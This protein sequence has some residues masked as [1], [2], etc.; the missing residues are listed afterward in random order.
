[1]TVAS[2]TNGRL[3]L[4]D[5]TTEV[6]FLGPGN[7]WRLADPY[8]RP[9]ISALKGGGVKRDSA[10]AD[11]QQLVFGVY[12]NA[13]ETIPLALH[14]RSQVA[15]IETSRI[16]LKLLR[17]AADY[18]KEPFEY[19]P[20]WIEAQPACPGALV[21]YARV[22]QG[23]L[24]ELGNVFGQ[25]FFAPQP[26][27][28]MEGLTLVLE[29]EPFWTSV[30]P[31][32]RLGPLYNLL[33][34][35]DFEL[36]TQR[37]GA[38]S[39]VEPDSW[40]N[41]A[42][43]GA[44]GR[45][46]RH[47]DHPN[48]GKHCLLVD[49]DSLAGAGEK[50]VYQVVEGIEDETEYTLILWAR[51][52]GIQYGSGRVW[53]RYGTQTLTVYASAARHDW[54]LYTGKFTT[55]RD[56]VVI[57]YCEIRGTGVG[58]I[59]SAAEG[60]VYFDSFMLLP[61]DWE[62]LAEA[63]LLPYLTSSHVVNHCDQPRVGATEAGDINYLD[64]WDVPGDV[65]ASVRLEMVNDTAAVT[66]NS[67]VEVIAACRVG[68][69]RTG[70][71]FLLDNVSDPPGPN[72]TSASSSDYAPIS[73]GTGWT[74]VLAKSVSGGAQVRANAGHYRVFARVRDMVASGPPTAK[75]R[76]T[77]WIGVS[78]VNLV[79]LDE[80][81]VPVSREY[82]MVDLTPYGIVNW[83]TKF[84]PDESASIGY[85]IEAK[86]ASG[87]ANLD[88]DYALALPC[89]GG[90]LI[91]DLDPPVSPD[92]S[93]VADRTSSASVQ[94][95]AVRTGGTK[96]FWEDAK[97]AAI[98]EV[99]ALKSFQGKLFV[100]G[101]LTATAGQYHSRAW[102]GKVWGTLNH[103]YAITAFE[104]F[105][106][107]LYAGTNTGR[108][109]S[110]TGSAWSLVYSLPSLQPVVAMRDYDGYLY[111]LER[112]G[113]CY[114]YSGTGWVL[115]F[116]LPLIG[117][118]LYAAGDYADLKVYN[119]RLFACQGE[120][121]PNV[122]V[123][124]G[125]TLALLG[126]VPGMTRSLALESYGGY[127]WVGGDGPS[128]GYYDGYSLK[129]DTFETDLS[130][131]EEVYALQEYDGEIYAIT[132]WSSSRMGKVYRRRKVEGLAEEDGLPIGADAWESV[133]K[134]RMCGDFAG[135]V[136]EVHDGILWAG[137]RGYPSYS[138][139]AVLLAYSNIGVWNKVADYRGSLF[140]APVRDSQG[141][142]RH[143]YVFSWD[144]DNQ[145]NVVDDKL[146][147]GVSFV[148]HYLALRGDG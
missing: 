119:N 45:N 125:I 148:P 49:I 143:R 84:L 55:G 50:G 35:P 12:S 141:V 134:S 4:T 41:A 73:V 7:G 39:G 93:I 68:E 95:S 140:W 24:A 130:D 33:K 10:L 36:W 64:V 144:R 120:C 31:G 81:A 32:E 137:S 96:I 46:M 107:K 59:Y 109:Y 131:S 37:P 25:P 111:V 38:V 65:D 5:G 87:L 11:G 29:R 105:T 63:G 60:K 16:L 79:V 112:L 142:R 54:K 67:P 129:S 56:D 83:D 71:V 13:V 17:Q 114:R 57:V 115:A 30:P 2:Q 80:V 61:G 99:M 26:E 146:L 69:R 121:G 62:S 117:S 91:A 1:V 135:R 106:G 113:A 101:Y 15:A 76:L 14:G 43:P 132:A 102:D 147:V 42:S 138:E 28:A 103:T 123:W 52:D 20:V 40:I 74:T 128:V 124:N 27:A 3:V 94:A 110:W 116:N 118:C 75:L 127:L 23:G 139:Y 66:W 58:P 136:L 34:N 48:S 22:V 145:V 97:L 89:D 9:Q 126:S 100:G 47:S 51:N 122:Y 98:S 77:F 133:P 21:G 90:S 53:V 92:N 85:K 86:R 19:K 82:C 108:V 88:V 70:D 72:D 44:V 78:N 6:D 8:W 18:W 104:E